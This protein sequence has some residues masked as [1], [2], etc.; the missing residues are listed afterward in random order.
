MKI[1]LPLIVGAVCRAPWGRRTKLARRLLPALLD[2]GITAI[3]EVCEFK[4]PADFRKDYARLT[5]MLGREDKTPSMGELEFLLSTHHRPVQHLGSIGWQDYAFL[6]AFVSILEPQRVIEVGTLTGFSAAIIAAALS[7]QHGSTGAASG[8]TIDFRRQCLIDETRP[9]GFEIPELIPHLTS[10]V[11]L[12]VPRDS[13]FVSELAK[14]DELEIVF[15]DAD[16]RHPQPLL[17]LLRLAP[18]VRIGGWMVLH[19][20][21][22]GTMGRKAVE[23]GQTLRW[24]ASYGAEWLFN[25]WPFRKISGGNIGA[26]RLPA[27]KSALIPFAVGL[28]KARFEITGKAGVQARRVLYQTIGQ[29]V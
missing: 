7:R 17:D 16:H 24:G 21:Q 10:M 9:T 19:D 11:R 25:H 23:A 29:L 1:S 13:A 6:T 22:W 18:F 2:E 20:I 14:P 26:I 28:M 8:D 3:A 27:D 4:T 15:I 5:A 12:H